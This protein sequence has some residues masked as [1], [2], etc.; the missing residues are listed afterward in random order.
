MI[1]KIVKLVNYS[2]INLLYLV[3]IVGSHIG[4]FIIL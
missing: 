1:T 3:K 4:T 2:T